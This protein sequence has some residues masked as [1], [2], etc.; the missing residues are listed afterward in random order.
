[1]SALAA[2]QRCSCAGRGC[3]RSPRQDQ[4]RGAL[5]MLCS[6]ACGE[7]GGGWMLLAFPTCPSFWRAAR[8]RNGELPGG[9]AA[10]R[11][12]ILSPPGCTAVGRSGEDDAGGVGVPPALGVGVGGAAHPPLG[13]RA[14][15]LGLDGQA[16]GVS[17]RWEQSTQDCP[18][19]WAQ[20][21]V[22]PTHPP[23]FLQPRGGMNSSPGARLWCIW[24]ALAP[25]EEPR[26]R[27]CA[28]CL[29]GRGSRK[30]LPVLKNCCLCRKAQISI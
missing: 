10:G 20:P 7:G 3:R 28:P 15:S 23:S 18:R 25:Q 21:L 12:L 6:A 14:L 16:Q 1:M 4:T 17:G 13:V 24:A 22:P 26:T 30:S 11:A 2:P 29:Q 8:V 19:S 27:R 9:A 5:V